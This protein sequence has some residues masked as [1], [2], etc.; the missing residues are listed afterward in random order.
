MRDDSWRLWQGQNEMSKSDVQI[1]ISTITVGLFTSPLG[2]SYS[3]IL[4]AALYVLKNIKLFGTEWPYIILLIIYGVYRFFFLSEGFLS[5]LN[6]TLVFSFMLIIKD[7]K[8]LKPTLFVQYYLLLSLVVVVLQVL[9]KETLGLFFNQIYDSKEALD[10]GWRPNGISFE[11]S[12][13]SI[14]VVLAG[15]CLG[16]SLNLFYTTVIGLQVFL[17]QSTFGIAGFLFLVFYRWFKIKYV[18]FTVPL[19][20][21]FLSCVNIEVLERLFAVLVKLSS[22]DITELVVADHSASIRIAPYLIL[23]TEP[24]WQNGVLLPKALI[25]YKDFIVNYLPGVDPNYWAGGGFLPSSLYTLG[26][27]AV[28]VY[29]F[30]YRHFTYSQISLVIAAIILSNISFSTQAFAVLLIFLKIGAE[31]DKNNLLRAC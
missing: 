18:V 21:I 5:I 19:L 14:F 24:W 17:F 4:L 15:Y 30:L 11:P 29:H 20:G 27:F 6:F 16:K 3:F 25:E 23:A 7:Y 22:F 28:I 31:N 12:V 8:P 1:F 2:V 9:L 10:S 26:V 13:A